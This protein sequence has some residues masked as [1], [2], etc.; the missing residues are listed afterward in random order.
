MDL[1]MQNAV[2][3]SEVRQNSFNMFNPSAK[4]FKTQS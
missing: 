4:I 3:N 2:N 1:S